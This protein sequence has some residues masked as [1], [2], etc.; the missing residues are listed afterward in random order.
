MPKEKLISIFIPTLNAGKNFENILKS[1]FNQKY[2]NF[3]VIII[4][5][6]SNDSTINIINKFSRENNISKL[7]LK[8]N[9][10]KNITLDNSSKIRL[11]HIKKKEFGH[12]RT[13]NLALKYAR[14]QIIVFLSQ[15]ALAR[16]N[17]WLTNLL[18]PLKNKGIGATFSRQIPYKNADITEKC[19]YSYY[20]QD[21]DTV[22][23]NLSSKNKLD[24]Y[25]FSNVSSAIKKDVL[26]KF[27]FDESLIM[28]EDQ[29]FA[30]KIIENKLKTYYCSKSV[31]IHSHN[32]NLM[33][34]FK[35]YFDSAFSLSQI[36]G[37]N[38][39]KICN[40]GLHYLIYELKFVLKKQPSKIFYLLLKDLLKVV[41]TTLGIYNKFI[42]TFIKKK[43]SLHSYYFDNR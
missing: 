27:P 9:T 41:A 7:E 21:K 33:L 28:S 34:T 1:I 10:Q 12:G 37:G 23:P 13:R 40:Y 18:N 43:L 24:N 30:K 5:S 25:F 39:R 26:K 11:L 22:K 36:F 4:D 20:F 15:D 2:K 42:P 14:G 32:Y 31:V 35:R 3:E 29:G 6:G 17:E 38:F 8:K 19:F 16:D